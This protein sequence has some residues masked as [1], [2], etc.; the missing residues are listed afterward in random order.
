MDQGSRPG[1]VT[2]GCCIGPSMGACV[3]LV[4]LGGGSTFDGPEEAFGKGM[5]A[6]TSPETLS[7]IERRRVGSDAAETGR[8]LLFS[9]AFRPLVHS[10]CVC[11]LSGTAG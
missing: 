4:H 11:P 5:G 6:W 7:A 2:P 3:E 9:T 1:D 8:I 10:R